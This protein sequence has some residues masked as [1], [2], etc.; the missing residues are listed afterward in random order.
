MVHNAAMSDESSAEPQAP[1]FAERMQARVA[2]LQVWGQEV[3][4]NFSPRARRN[5]RRAF[6][7]AFI[8]VIGTVL[9]RQL[10]GTDWRAVLRSL[11]AS[12]WFYLLFLARFFLQPVVEVLCYT[13]VWG[14]NLFRHF[15]VFLVKLVMNTSVAGMSGDMYFLMWAVRT[16]R[17]SYRKAFSGVK[18]VTLLSAAAANM[19]AVF[20][21]GG[22]LIFGDLT[23]MQ[24][25]RPQVLGV[26]IGVTLAAALLSLLVIAFRG[27]VLG[28]ATGTMWRV[29]GYHLVRSG[30]NLVLLGFQWTA[31][32]PGSVFSV[33]ISLLVVDLL[34]SRTPFI[35]AR[36]F[37]FLS[38]ALAMADTIDAP[39]A[40]V[41]AMFLA[42]TAMRQ[43]FVIPSLIM[44][45]FWRSRPQPLPLD[46][47][48]K[49]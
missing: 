22:Y 40:Q 38:L 3:F 31:G 24:K 33:W 26:I 14:V 13:A 29:I 32:L 21:L 28:I 39:Q 49:P 12:P 4:E 9:Y 17:I 27:K 25:V 16:L 15:G 10:A 8:L 34:T 7:L 19:V 42:D 44:G 23:L 30:G 47:D 6:S 43:A 48:S 5:L 11:P 20:V 1:R 37:L 18:D 35:P 46:P 36:E 45:F 2:R 41:T